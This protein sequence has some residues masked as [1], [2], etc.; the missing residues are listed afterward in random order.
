MEDSIYR[1]KKYYDHS[2]TWL[3][4]LI[5]G[6]Y[7]G[8]PI[9]FRYGRVYKYYR[10]LLR[11]SQY[12]GKEKLNEYQL[13]RLNRL[14]NHAYENVPYYR[15]VFDKQGLKP[16][17]IKTLD[18]I[19]KLP[20]LTKDL[21][22]ENLKD[23][24]AINYPKDKLLFQT[25]G[26]STGSP[27][28]FYHEKE[29]A[30]PKEVAFFEA[31]WSRVGYRWWKDRMVSLRGEGIK[32]KDRFWDYEPIRNNLVLS[33]YQM[34]E[35]NLPLYIKKIR[36]FKPQFLYIYPS[37]VTILARFMK[38][39]QVPAFD[40]LVAIL[41][42]SEHLFAYQRQL[43]QDV[44]NCKILNWYGM[45][46]KVVLA[47]SCEESTYYHI[48]PEYG[49]TELVERDGSQISDEGK[50]GEI[51]GTVFDN[52]IMPF[53]RYKTGDLGTYTNKKCSCRRNY[54]LLR[55]IEGRIQEFIVSRHGSLIPLN[56]LMVSLDAELF[57]DSNKGWGRISQFQF[58]Q[59][60]RGKLILKVI[61][62]N[63][64]PMLEA[65]KYIRDLFKPRLQSLCDFRIDFVKDIPRTERGKH[66]FL[67]QNLDLAE[68]KIKQEKG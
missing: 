37:A 24:I 17:D 58:I 10:D 64:F 42:G 21:V 15:R 7:R 18:D 67:V 59:Q 53:I 40:G 57:S 50:V 28:I 13:Q 49:I 32:S 38:N 29:V 31:M 26:G 6:L 16:R 27:L 43:L 9:S 55:D 46:E 19:I 8:I 41:C 45:G 47:G 12:W 22:R 65:Q 51:V 60:E 11:G 52:D 4:G 35:K 20:F 62:A 44:F 36:A 61:K 34:N 68:Y 23:L 54:P 14:L 30:R 63:D 39:H 25:T 48:F 5:G 2:P 66:K 33:V 1:F 56:G 3:K